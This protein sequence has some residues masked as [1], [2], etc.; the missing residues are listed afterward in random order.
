M[1]P[2]RQYYSVTQDGKKLYLSSKQIL[3]NIPLVCLFIPLYGLFASRYIQFASEIYEI[4][5][6]DSVLKEEVKKIELKYMR[7]RIS[8]LIQNWK[9]WFTE[10]QPECKGI[11]KN[12][13]N[14][15]N[16][17]VDDD[18]IH[19]EYF[20]IR[21]RDRQLYEDQ[22][23]KWERGERKAKPDGWKYCCTLKADNL[24]TNTIKYLRKFKSHKINSI[25][26][27]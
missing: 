18:I 13:D 8:Y 9:N 4:A 1:L 21:H 17:Y 26:D 5:E 16:N 23:L 12:G 11:F 20:E 15:S 7:E 3:K 14:I 6:K 19:R 25:K 10:I 27:K 24:P 22:K 2:N